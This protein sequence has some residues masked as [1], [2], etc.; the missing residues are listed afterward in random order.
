MTPFEPAAQPF[1]LSTKARSYIETGRL[2]CEP[3]VWPPSVVPSIA[4]GPPTPS[5]SPGRG[6]APPIHPVFASIKKTVVGIC[7]CPKRDGIHETP[8]SVV[9]RTTPSCPE[10]APTA[11]PASGLMKWIEFSV[12]TCIRGMLI[13]ISVQFCPPSIVFRTTP[14]LSS[15]AFGPGTSPQTKTTSGDTT[16][17]PL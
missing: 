15:S 4:L 6:V 10:S 13:G 14:T 11:H 1:I 7:L 17:M 2:Y 12:G 8:P 3:H 5:S 16:E 9:R